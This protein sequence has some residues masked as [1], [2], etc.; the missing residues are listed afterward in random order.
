MPIYDV[1]EARAARMAARGEQ[2][3]SF[4]YGGA[5]FSIPPEMPLD[6]AEALADGNART[7]M[8][9]ILD[10]QV[11]KFWEM[12]PS[13]YDV[14]DLITWLSDTVYAI[15]EPGESSASS[16]TSGKTGGRSRRPSNANTKST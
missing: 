14:R 12:R 9:V 1:D 7:F 8:A 5:S 2:E 6:A 10:G 16:A 3:D 4:R 13:L 15:G 11:D